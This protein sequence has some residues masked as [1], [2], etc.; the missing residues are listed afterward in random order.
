MIYPRWVKTDH[1]ELI[2]NR[3]FKAIPSFIRM[4]IFRQVAKGV[5]KSADGHGI[6]RHTDAEVYELGLDDVKTVETF[7]GIM[8]LCSAI[9]LPKSTRQSLLFYMA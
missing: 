9:N 6:A 1:H 5:A 4:P 7:W 2:A 8:L 3:L